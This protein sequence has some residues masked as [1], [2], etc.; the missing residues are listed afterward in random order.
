MPH[1]RRGVIVFVIGN[2]VRVSSQDLCLDPGAVPPGT[3]S[4]NEKLTLGTYK[5]G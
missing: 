3:V 5:Q 4:R 2:H 1:E